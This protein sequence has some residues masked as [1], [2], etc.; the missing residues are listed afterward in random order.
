MT[1]FPAT[2]FKICRRSLVSHCA[3]VVRWL[4][5]K[6]TGAFEGYDGA[7]IE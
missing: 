4:K 5:P 1:F 7:A 2:Q 6:T 3:I